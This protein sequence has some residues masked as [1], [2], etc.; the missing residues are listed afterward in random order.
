MLNKKEFKKIRKEISDSDAKRESTIQ[1]SREIISL[2]K[3]II[4]ALHRND[5]K[6]ASSYVKDIE[7]K[8]ATLEHVSLDTNINQTALQEYAEALCYYH[9]IKDK[10][11]PTKDSLKISNE[12]YLMGL[13]DLTGELVR[14]AVNEVINKNFKKAFEIKNL[15]EEIYGEFLEFNLR[16]GEL[17]RK[18]DQIKWNLKK[19]ED[20]VFELK[21]KGKL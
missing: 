16:N 21:L 9:Y 6:S 15:V 19:L 18:S 11:I 10:K 17:R 14:K 20:V 4:Y 1:Q 3:R 2:S 7:K 5:I 12:S 8:K 13:C